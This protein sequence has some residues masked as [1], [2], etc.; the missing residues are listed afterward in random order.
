MVLRANGKEFGVYAL[1]VAPA[2]LIYIAVIAYPV[3]FSGILGFTSYNFRPGEEFTFIGFQQYA[4][5]L[6]DPRFW[7]GFRNNL[8]VVAVSV[9]GQIPL[10]F[11]LAYLLYRRY[12]R[13]QHFFQA[14]VFLPQAISLIVV[15]ILWRN[16]FGVQGALTEIVSRILG[17]P[18]FRFTWFRYPETAMFPVAIALLW[19]YVGF[20]LIVFLANLQTI[21]KSVIESA[22]IDGAN[23]PQIFLRI[24]TPAMAGVILV[25]T[26]L[27]IS[28]SFKGFDLIFALAPNEGMGLANYN[29]VLPTYMYHYA[30][31]SQHYAFGSAISNVIVLLSVA[32]IIV[33]RFV[34]RR[35]SVN[36]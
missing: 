26:I 1:L 3:I 24:V 36:L 32:M 23:E 34:H 10:G 6:S 20:Y 21:E 9:F 16:M 11:V 35:L 7:I 4:R 29:L 31:S 13:Y 22:Q 5:M 17:D 30:F 19:I 33:A 14:M 12:V 25:N 27:A 18:S 28:G 2:L 15:G 8:I